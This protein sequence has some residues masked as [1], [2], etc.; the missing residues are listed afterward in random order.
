MDFILA[1]QEF[2]KEIYHASCAIS[3]QDGTNAL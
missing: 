3:H 2:K 1:S